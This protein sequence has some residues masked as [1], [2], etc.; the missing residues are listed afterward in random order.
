MRLPLLVTV[1]FLS[2]SILCRA[3][4]PFTAAAA[5]DSGALSIVRSGEP[6]LGFEYYDWGDGWSGVERK[7]TTVEGVKEVSFTYNNTLQKT[8]TPFKIEGSWKQTAADTFRFKAV[9]TPEGSAAITMAQFGLS[10]GAAFQ[11]REATVVSADGTRTVSMI[12]FG[13]G[14]LGN[15]V[16]ELSLKDAEGN[17][18]TLTFD[19]PALIMTHGQARLVLVAEKMEAGKT[20]PL[21]FTLKLPAAANFYPG[22]KSV[23]PSTQGWYEFKG[24]SPIP[25]TSEWNMSAWLEK[26]AGKFGRIAR[27]DD[28]LIYNSKPIKLWGVNVSY[29]A[30]APETGVAD[31]RAD[32]YAA[33]GVNAVRLHKYA[34]GFG[35]A[36]IQSKESAADFD[37]AELEKMDYFV[38]ALKQR[39]IYVKLS[40]VFII[41]P[42]PADRARVPFLDEFGPMQGD[43]VNPKHGSLYLSSELQDLLIEQTTRLLTHQNP[44]TKLT[45][46]ADPAV[47]YFELYNEDSSLFGGVTAVMAQSPTLRARGGKMFSEWLKKKYPDEQAFLAAW[48][49]GT[50]NCNILSNQGLPVDES[51]TENRIYPAGNPWF[52]DPENLNA[53]QSPFKRRLLDT[54][55]FLYD[56]QNQVYARMTKAVRATGYMGEIIASNWQAGRAMSHYYNLSSDAM[57]GT[58][59]RHNYF[60]GGS[61][62]FFSSSSMIAIPGGGSL[63]ASLQQV[64]DRP[65]MLSEWIHVFPN[66]WTVEGPAI[67]GAYGMG[68]QGWD[69]SFPFQNRDEGTFAKAIGLQEWDVASP[70][71]LGIFPAVSRQV[72]RGDV[73]E[74]DVV[75]TRNVNI[76]SLDQEKVGFEDKVT[77]QWD[78]KTFD[79]DVFPARALA[80]ARSVVSFTDKFKPTESFDLAPYEK[81]GVINSS[82]GQLSWTEGKTPQD[83]HIEINT[84][85][86]QAVVGF[87]KGLTVKLADSWI[88]PASRFG[89]IYLSAQS[90]EGTIAKDRGVLITALS[91]AR[92]QDAVI[93]DDSFLFSKGVRTA[94][95]PPAGPVVMEPVLADIAFRRAGRLTVHILDHNGVKTGKTV[96]VVDGKFRID[97]GRDQTPYY[98]VTW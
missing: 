67:I 16:K 17:V 22:P 11:G 84:P 89:A 83:G 38:A 42:G 14:G 25:A 30:C 93:A 66:E 68:L 36:G 31:R 1:V 6:Y 46:A 4:A 59:D 12:P 48:G 87:T 39:G 29:S 79:T 45:Y 41:R 61:G 94:T 3:E 56:L 20:Y 52:F 21:G 86:T 24:E 32:F 58:I 5:S 9:L 78:Q 53:S 70:V 35:W 54:M 40:P 69:V 71:F 64:G 88:K 60:G 73:K 74:S 23:P 57:I 72:L 76:A 26:P 51:W 7:M 15:A 47:A 19:P 92:N 91:R 63:S 8:N 65:F 49:E 37:P 55:A 34:D 44:H 43:R 62:F 50:L 85:G 27:K 28:K 98:L 96:P 75:H 77:Q 2:A 80:A 95:W 33:L 82:T 81:D 13:M 90:P 18:A 10:P 97:T